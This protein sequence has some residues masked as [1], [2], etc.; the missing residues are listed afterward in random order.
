MRCL[1]SLHKRGTYIDGIFE[2]SDGD[3]GTKE[4]GW[5]VLSVH[6]LYQNVHRRGQLYSIVP[7]TG[8][9]VLHKQNMTVIGLLRM[10]I[11]EIQNK[12]KDFKHLMF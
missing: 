3:G 4:P 2:H 10:A 1:T 9:I 11:G 6:H 12:T 8:G 5:G 7:R